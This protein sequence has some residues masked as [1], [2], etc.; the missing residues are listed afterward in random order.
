MAL[1]INEFGEVID[2]ATAHRYYNSLTMLEGPERDAVEGALTLY[3]QKQ[4][5]ERR[6]AS[7]E[8]LKP[9]FIDPVEFDKY[10]MD[11]AIQE[12][13]KWSL[14]PDGVKYGVAGRE[15]MAGVL[16]RPVAGLEYEKA[17]DNYAK[18]HWGMEEVDDKIFHKKLS[19][20]FKTIDVLNTA[21][22]DLQRDFIIETAT[23]AL[24]GRPRDLTGVFN[25]WMADRREIV[26]DEIEGQY[27]SEANEVANQTVKGI[28]VYA[29][30]AGA[31]MQLMNNM[32]AGTSTPEEIEALGKQ[33]GK[34]PAAERQRI[35]AFAAVAA[36]DLTPDQ[37]AS[38]GKV[39]EN[40]AR[41]F[42]RTVGQY[43]EALQLAPTLQTR[44][45]SLRAEI[46]RLES[47]AALPKPGAARPAYGMP[48]LEVPLPLEQRTARIATA[49]EELGAIQAI[50]ELKHTFD[51][52]VNPIRPVFK[53]G[54]FF[55]AGSLEAGFYGLTGSLPYM[56][57]A[58]LDVVVPFLG[59]AMNYVT[60]QESEHN[61]MMIENPNMD[62]AVA[63]ATSIFSAA[64]QAAIEKMKLEIMMGH[65]PVTAQFFAGINNKVGRILAKGAVGVSAEVLE[66][67][68]QNGIS[69]FTPVLLSHLRTD[70]PDKDPVAALRDW[71]DEGP[72][73]FWAM[74]LPGMTGG[75]FAALQDIKDLNS[76]F[77]PRVLDYTG[78]SEQ[79]KA[80]IRNAY[81]PAEAARA[82]FPNRTPENIAKG[83]AM[84][85][86]DIE[87]ATAAQQD[88]LQPTMEVITLADGTKEYRVLRSVPDEIEAEFLPD[89]ELEGQQVTLQFTDAETG[90]TVTQVYDAVEAQNRVK[91]N[92]DTYKQLIDCL[93]K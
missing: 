83:I 30:Q 32:K 88:P 41:F 57:V 7:F 21:R 56:A 81:D 59:T 33:L 86:A 63:S 87:A 4:D 66:E 45:L 13:Q 34:I 10:G 35:N 62:P 9:I 60:M 70:M 37:R 93:G 61:R 1:G 24:E 38:L 20:D 29:P 39:L 12:A 75:G 31:V 47:G 43:G 55:S 80:A 18:A 82:E 27:F 52:K 42:G 23:A 48:E 53:P 5:E 76:V 78:Y 73:V 3:W 26:P 44:E 69:A 77:S 14:D 71:V 15:F 51:N 16:G 28:G 85:E 72:A 50:R 79:Q 17:R 68:L 25:N 84:L 2:D 46:T 90:R 36:S 64:P 49:K 65:L 89:E 67:A 8:R 11:P 74:L 6:E 91:T 19:E 92:L 54:G 40:G 58:A 22:I